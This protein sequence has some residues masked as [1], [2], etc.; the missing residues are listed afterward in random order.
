M[1]TVFAFLLG[2]VG[3]VIGVVK[4]LNTWFDK[5]PT[6]GSIVMISIFLFLVLR[7]YSRALKNQI[8]QVMNLI[9]KIEDKRHGSW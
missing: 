2:I 7:D 1:E 6:N 9:N 5:P 8:N 4:D 3:W